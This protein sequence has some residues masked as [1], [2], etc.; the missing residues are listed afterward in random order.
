VRVFLSV[1][2]VNPSSKNME[3]TSVVDQKLHTNRDKRR[4]PIQIED[5]HC[6]KDVLSHLGVWQMGVYLVNLSTD[7]LH[8]RTTEPSPNGV[9]EESTHDLKVLQQTS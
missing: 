3:K 2:V 4:G 6:N 5:V 8:Y 1:Q 7:H 9:P